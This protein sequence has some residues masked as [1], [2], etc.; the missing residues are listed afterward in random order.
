MASQPAKGDL[1]A[2]VEQMRREMDL[3]LENMFAQPRARPWTPEADVYETAD[4]VLVCLDVPGCDTSQLSIELRGRRLTIRGERK[5][6]VVARGARVLRM[7]RRQGRFLKSLQLSA[8]VDV[9]RAEVKEDEGT[10]VIGLPKR[11]RP[12][13]W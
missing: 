6:T 10:L 12:P 1:F 3:M 7:E 5:S 2:Q 8:D 13:E 4:T 11:K 9:E